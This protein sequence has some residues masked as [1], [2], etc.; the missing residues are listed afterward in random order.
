MQPSTGLLVLHIGTW[1]SSISIYLASVYP[2][3]WIM[4][5]GMLLVKP[6]AF[7]SSKYQENI[8]SQYASLMTYR[9]DMVIDVDD[10]PIFFT[11]H[12]G[13][14]SSVRLIIHHAFCYV[15]LYAKAKLCRGRLISTGP[16]QSVW[17]GG[18][19][20]FPF[21]RSSLKGNMKFTGNFLMN[22]QLC[23]IQYSASSLRDVCV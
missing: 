3:K 18:W 17:N 22:G 2:L 23:I 16:W 5:W 15:C 20:L 12:D 9:E 8:W 14:V 1:E 11:D 21:L 13:H 7:S 4:S 10:I 6:R 19:Q